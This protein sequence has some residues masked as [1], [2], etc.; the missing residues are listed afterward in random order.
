MLQI[1]WCNSALTGKHHWAIILY[2]YVYVLNV[3]VS[4]CIWIRDVELFW[5]KRKLEESSLYSLFTELTCVGRR[6]IATRAMKFLFEFFFAFRSAVKALLLT[7]L[8]SNDIV[9]NVLFFMMKKLFLLENTTNE[10][11]LSDKLFQWKHI[12]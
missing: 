8:V 2:M 4:C 12:C 10:A 9:A 7:A 11:T 5:H 6:A 3:I 1:A